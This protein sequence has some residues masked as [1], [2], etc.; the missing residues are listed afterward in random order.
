[1][2]TGESLPVSR[3][4]GD[5]V[6]GATL[7][8]QRLIKFKA[9]FVGRETALAQIIR[10]VEQA[11]GSRAP[12]LRLVDRVSAAFVPAGTI[13]GL[14]VRRGG[15]FATNLIRNVSVFG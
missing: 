14:G 3:T 12:I 8:K 5:E 2:I 10:L 11:Q 7:N 9:T 15:G 1:M 13:I 6:I 4:V